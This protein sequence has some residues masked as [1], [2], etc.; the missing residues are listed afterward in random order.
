MAYQKKQLSFGSFRKSR[1][2]G[3]QIAISYEFKNV[4]IFKTAA[5]L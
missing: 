5:S 1:N 2:E 4:L 3:P